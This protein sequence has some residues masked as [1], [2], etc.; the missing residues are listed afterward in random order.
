[1]TYEDQDNGVAPIEEQF[2]LTPGRAD[3][4]H[5][6]RHLPA[7]AQELPTISVKYFMKGG[8]EFLGPELEGRRQ[9]LFIND[10]FGARQ[11]VGVRGVGD[12][13]TRI[14]TI[15]V[16]LDYDDAA[17]KLHPDQEHGARRHQPFFDW[18]FPV[19]N[20]TGGKV[21]YKA[22]VAYK[23][24]TNEESRRPSATSNTILLPPAI[25]AFLEVQ[26]VT[27]LIDWAAGAAG[28]RLAELCRS[29]QPGRRERRT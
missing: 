25:E 28:A 3:P 29:G 11:T 1:M 24:G 6:A 2:Q 7:D 12:F 15:F 27:D 17:N 22:T 16:D 14:Q 19:I 26:M 8:R 23:D 21:T 18:T 5:P 20:E 13:A 10:V 9:K 4:P